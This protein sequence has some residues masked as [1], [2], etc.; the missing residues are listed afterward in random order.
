MSDEEPKSTEISIGDIY[1][2]LSAAP[3]PPSK[4]KPKTTEEF[5]EIEDTASENRIRSSC[6]EVSG[7]IEYKNS[8]IFKHHPVAAGIKA[9]KHKSPIFTDAPIMAAAIAF[10]IQ[11][12]N[13]K[14][15]RLKAADVFKNTETA[16]LIP[17]IRAVPEIICVADHPKAA[18]FAQKYNLSVA[19]AG[20]MIYRD[21]IKNSIVVIG[22]DDSALLSVCRLAER[23][24]R[25][26]LILGFP[27]GLNTQ[28][29][30]KRYLAE[31]DLA[32]PLITMPHTKGGI[33]AA[34]ACFVELMKIYEDGL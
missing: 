15:S 21:D 12:E 19:A 25:P 27:A 16:K 6:I 17:K 34:A 33:E 3:V 22:K 29:D 31:T 8:L 9:F 30:A 7:D 23:G 1:D 11:E 5:E 4:E 14:R 2:N 32:T 26:Y 28:K 10:R 20:F 13:S 18:E 24:S